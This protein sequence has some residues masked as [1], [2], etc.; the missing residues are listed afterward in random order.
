M[1]AAVETAERI[2]TAFRFT[3][4]NLIKDLLLNPSIKEEAF[5]IPSFL[6]E[7]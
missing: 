2:G 7:N 6:K 4:E 1:S 5:I 3:F